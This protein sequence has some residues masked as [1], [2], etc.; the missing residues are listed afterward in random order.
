MWQRAKRIK[1][2][3]LCGWK[4]LVLQV[5]RTNEALM[6]SHLLSRCSTIAILNYWS[7]CISVNVTHKQGCQLFLFLH[8]EGPFYWP[9]HASLTTVPRNNYSL[10]VPLP[11]Q[12]E[13]STAT[14]KAIRT[15]IPAVSTVL[16]TTTYRLH[17]ILTCTANQ[18]LHH[19]WWPWV[20]W[21]GVI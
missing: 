9:W 11:R 12:E 16:P 19:S 15:F 1:L 10:L 21:V 6:T 2:F 18:N 7:K 8:R 5:T 13:I 14:P 17:F 20:A 3:A 4:I